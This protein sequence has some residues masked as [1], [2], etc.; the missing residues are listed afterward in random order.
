MKKGSLK[1]M[2]RSGG[3]GCG[4]D[5]GGLPI[6]MR[7]HKCHKP[8]WFASGK[9]SAAAAREQ[10]QLVATSCAGMDVAELN[11]SKALTL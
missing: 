6:C 2:G 1:G 9:A 8:Q 3:N 5:D 7:S 10:E 11:G 4:P